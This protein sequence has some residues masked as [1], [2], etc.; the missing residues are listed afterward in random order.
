MENWVQLIF[1]AL[2][3]ILKPLLRK[4][5]SGEALQIWYVYSCQHVGRVS[6]AANSLEEIKSVYCENCPAL[7]NAIKA[8][9]LMCW[10]RR[11]GTYLRSSLSTKLSAEDIK[12]VSDRAA[13]GV[14][15][16]RSNGSCWQRLSTAY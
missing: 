2:L 10:L 14:W 6:G 1:D 9:R 16:L 5:T 11:L 13:H 4:D 3:D 12:S 7:S 15:H 8:R